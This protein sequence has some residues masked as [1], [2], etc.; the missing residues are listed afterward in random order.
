MKENGVKLDTVRKF[1]KGDFSTDD[2]KSKVCI[3][4]WTKFLNYSFY[5]FQC[6]LKCF[7][8]NIGLFDKEGNVEMNYIQDALV[9]VVK[10]EDKVNEI[11]KLLK[12]IN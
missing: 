7:A 11:I 4:S 8:T 1:R 3:K 6:F 9:E 5:W 10:D 12:F 2:D